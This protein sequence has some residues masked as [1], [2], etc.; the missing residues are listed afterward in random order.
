MPRLTPN[1]GPPASH[2]MEHLADVVNG[3]GGLVHRGRHVDLEWLW[4]VD[5]V[6]Y[7]VRIQHGLV[8]E[9]VRGPVL[10]RSHRFAVRGPADSWERFWAPMP[11]PGFHDL[12]AMMKTGRA[13]IDGDLQPLMANLRYFKE[14]LAAPRRLADGHHG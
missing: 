6:P 14:V 8:V 10:M 2:A 3:D 1:G 9:L 13:S 4:Q 12:F 11:R 5:A 7:H